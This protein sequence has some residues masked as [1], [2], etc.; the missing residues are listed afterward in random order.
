MPTPTPVRT[1]IIGN[2]KTALAG[3]TVAGGYLTTVR[4]VLEGLQP[5]GEQPSPFVLVWQPEPE[6]YVEISSS[7][8]ERTLA[9][10]VSGVLECQEGAGSGPRAEAEK[11]LADMEKAILADRTR[12]GYATDTQLTRNQVFDAEPGLPWVQVSLGVRIKYRT[13]RTDPFTAS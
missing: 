8:V 10:E 3:I 12:G 5:Q 2:L 4:A 13:N 7:K 9:L 1:S 6:T 11:L